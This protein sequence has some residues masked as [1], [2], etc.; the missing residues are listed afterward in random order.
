MDH[1][2]SMM[3]KHSNNLEKLIEARTKEL[4][5][6]KKLSEELLY[7]ML[8]RQAMDLLVVNELTG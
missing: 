2:V 1:L 3:E 6:E 5:D 8:P 7:S 4:M